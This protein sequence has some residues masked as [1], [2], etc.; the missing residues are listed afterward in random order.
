M[1]TVVNAIIRAFRNVEFIDVYTTY[2]EF[3]VD[4]HKYTIDDE[5][6]TVFE[7]MFRREDG[8]SEMEVTIHSKC[9][10]KCVRFEHLR[11]KTALEVSRG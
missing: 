6:M 8:V 5:S 9:V 4:G 1:H 11:H 3:L 2:V 10:Q 7:I